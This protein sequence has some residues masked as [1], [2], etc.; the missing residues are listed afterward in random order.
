MGGERSVWVDGMMG[1]REEEE[2][3]EERFFV[4]FNEG[5]LHSRDTYPSEHG[6]RTRGA[7][8][9]KK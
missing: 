1:C 4:F 5:F 6:R 9:F 7:K 3:E 8:G 2:E